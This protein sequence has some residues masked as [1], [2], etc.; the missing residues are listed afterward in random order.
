MKQLK[1]KTSIK[2]L[3]KYYSTLQQEH[4]DKL[5]K[6]SEEA[7]KQMYKTIGKEYTN[8]TDTFH[9]FTVELIKGSQLNQKIMEEILY[10]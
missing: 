8:N 10:G 4:K 7:T 9:K 6:Q 3:K 1:N 5:Q 2:Q